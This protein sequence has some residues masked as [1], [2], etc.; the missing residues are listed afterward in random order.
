MKS[1]AA[2]IA[3]PWTPKGER[4]PPPLCS[5]RR[6]R[7]SVVLIAPARDHKGFVVE[8]KPSV[9]AQD[10]LGGLKV[11]AVCDH[12]VESLVFNLVHINRGIPGREQRRGSNP[13]PDLRG[14]SVHFIPKQRLVIRRR[15]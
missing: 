3:H 13:I 5:S 14:Q 9:L 15:G 8:P 12:G 10:L 2:G 6:T 7:A 1:L 11:S 4:S